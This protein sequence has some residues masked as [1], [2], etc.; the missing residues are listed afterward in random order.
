MDC[1]KRLVPIALGKHIVDVQS[2]KHTL[3]LTDSGAV[4]SCG[5][6]EFGQTGRDGNLSIPKIISSL[7]AFVVV[8]VAV[9]DDYSLIATSTGS[10][11]SWGRNHVG[12]LGHGNRTD[13]SKPRKL[14]SL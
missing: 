9:G 7:D 1:S 12:Q 11:F 10:V 5:N 3:F 8:S 13:V 4:W 2:K 6:N 14:W